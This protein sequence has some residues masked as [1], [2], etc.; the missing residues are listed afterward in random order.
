[1]VPDTGQEQGVLSKKGVNLEREAVVVPSS[2]PSWRCCEQAEQ[3]RGADNIAAKAAATAPGG[4]ESRARGGWGR[5]RG[6][7]GLGPR[8]TPQK[9]VLA[10]PARPH[11][12]PLQLTLI[13]VQN[14]LCLHSHPTVAGA[15]LRN[16]CAELLP[17]RRAWARDCS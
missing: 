17:P 15:R 1:M 4:W 6:E 3:S 8:N 10:K 5:G 11:R 7:A 12:F 14:F 13:S 2:P 16:A 9:M